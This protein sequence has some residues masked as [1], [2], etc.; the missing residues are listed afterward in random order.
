MAKPNTTGIAKPSE[1]AANEEAIS[2]LAER[3][4]LT[5]ETA[6]LRLRT[7]L[8]RSEPDAGAEDFQL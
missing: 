5:E 1:E 2:H 8:D 6:R 7:E 3:W 4:N